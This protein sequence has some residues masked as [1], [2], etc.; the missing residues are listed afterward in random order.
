M[1]ND[2]K[3]DTQ[4]RMAK[5]VDALRHSLTKIRTGRASPSLVDHLK[6]NY[7]GSEMP[8]LWR[9]LHRPA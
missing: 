5:S 9:S 4:A 7:Y 1:L 6:I 2:I 3:K 8:L